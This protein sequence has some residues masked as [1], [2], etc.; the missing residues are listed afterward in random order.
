M[1]EKQQQLYHR[2]CDYELGDPSHEV[3][4]LAHLMYANG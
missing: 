4:F 1:L 3:G 2:I